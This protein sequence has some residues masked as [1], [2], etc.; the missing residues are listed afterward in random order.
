MDSVL[1]NIT[2]Q[3]TLALDYRFCKPGEYISNNSCVECSYGSYSLQWNSTTCSQW[4][5]NASCLGKDQ[6]YVEAGYWRL[7]T[8]STDIMGC[9]NQNAWVGGYVKDSDHPVNWSTGYEGRLCSKWE[10]NDGDKYQ[11]VNDFDWQK[12]PD[13]VLNAIRVLALAFLVFIFIMIIIIVNVRKTSE[14]EVSILLRILTNYFQLISLTMSF[15]INYPK[16]LTDIFVPVSSIGDS[17]DTFLSFDCFAT[18]Y[19]ITGPFPS[20]AFLKL[21]LTMFLP[22]I[23]FFLVTWIW[24]IVYLIKKKYVKDM[25]R[26]L[27]ISFISIVFL[28]HPKLTQQSINIF[29]W[30]DID[31]STS[32]MRM[33][34]D[35]KW[36]SAEHIKWSFLLGFPILSIWVIGMPV[37]ITSTIICIFM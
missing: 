30:V 4:P 15:S 11:K 14:S 29:R 36:Y 37:L 12:C 3:N 16:S 6:I 25:K 2:H 35:I 23:L 21:F 20:S 31:S 34:T 32:V 24:T 18:D 10:I 7:N 22:I 33:D 1:G 8:N 26:Y 17:S 19:D 5:D 28:L 13:P 9:I 27:V